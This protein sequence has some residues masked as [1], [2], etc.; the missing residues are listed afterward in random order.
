MQIG[1][2]VS[3]A[4]AIGP[5]STFTA[6][7][8]TIVV[9]WLMTAVMAAILI[10]RACKR[11]SYRGLSWGTWAVLVLTVIVLATLMTVHPHG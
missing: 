8:P 1:G 3:G 2:I 5:D 11:L 6:T 9:G 4:V 10:T 7:H